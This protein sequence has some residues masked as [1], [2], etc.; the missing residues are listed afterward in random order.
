[1]FR[2]DE[3]VLKNGTEYFGEYLRTEADVIHFKH[4]EGF[5]AYQHTLIFTLKLKDG[6][7]LIDDGIVTKQTTLNP[8]QFEK[9]P[10]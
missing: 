6:R 8:E 5:L 2:L 1:M 7:I 10:I 3:L 9:L 4:K